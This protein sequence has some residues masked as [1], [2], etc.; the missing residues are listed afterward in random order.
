MATYMHL[1]EQVDPDEYVV[2]EYRVTTDIPME[3]AAASIAAEQSTGTW[4][5]LTTTTERIVG[6]YGAKV[7]S[8]EGD[9]TVIAYPVE[10]FSI[11]VGGVPLFSARKARAADAAQGAETRKAR[12]A[13]TRRFFLEPFEIQMESDHPQ[14]F[15]LQEEHDPYHHFRNGVHGADLNGVRAERFFENGDGQRIRGDPAIRCADQI[16]G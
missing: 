6:D 14:Y 3:K 10:D 15:P 12:L 7:L 9:R 4:T 5:D 11:D 13:R 16:F 1:G 2:C 8:I